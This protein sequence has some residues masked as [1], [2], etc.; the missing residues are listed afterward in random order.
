MELFWSAK[1]QYLQLIYY[2]H[3]QIIASKWESLKKDK[4]ESNSSQS[5]LFIEI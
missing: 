2:F 5:E 1:A 3:L 4:L